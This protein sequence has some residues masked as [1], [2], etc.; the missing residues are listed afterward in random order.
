MATDS[1]KFSLVFELILAKAAPSST[2]RLSDEKFF[3]QGL[4]DFDSCYFERSPQSVV[5]TD[6][7]SS[8]SP[9]SS[10]ITFT[11][12]S[13]SSVASSSSVDDHDQD[14]R[15]ELEEFDHLLLNEFLTNSF[16]PKS[17]YEIA[18]SSREKERGRE[19]EQFANA[20]LS[21]S[22]ENLERE[23][24]KELEDFDHLLSD[25]YLL[26]TT[27]PIN[28][29]ELA[30]EEGEKEALQDRLHLL[31]V[32]NDGLEQ[33]MS[34]VKSDLSELT[35][36]NQKLG[37]E[38]DT[39]R[40]IVC[41]LSGVISHGLDI[42]PPK[43]SSVDLEYFIDCMISSLVSKKSQLQSSAPITPTQVSTM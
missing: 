27:S 30:E 9:M 35:A 8:S 37:S 43:L 21:S 10:S 36:V 5:M 24:R 19:K 1:N 2:I 38:R 39:L 11:A 6:A 26:D 32:R 16:V 29:Y 25:E 23:F 31:L 22:T 28:P 20:A 40:R 15:R 13:I 18:E 3:E 4:N 14:F 34:S 12:A 41:N 7:S 33:E 17:K 42:S